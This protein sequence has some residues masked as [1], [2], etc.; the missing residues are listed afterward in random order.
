M[1]KQ[2][3]LQME[4]L[5]VLVALVLVQDIIHLITEVLVKQFN[6]LNQVIQAHMVLEILAVTDITHHPQQVLKLVV[7]EV[8]AVAEE[9]LD[10]ITLAQVV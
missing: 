5:M 9:T 2:R 10:Q 7:A 8:P 3:V 6:Q 4:V 1:D